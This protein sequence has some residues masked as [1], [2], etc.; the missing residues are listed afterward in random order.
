M[1]LGDMV[2]A[3]GHVGVAHEYVM[4]HGYVVSLGDVVIAHKYVMAHE[5]VMS[6][7][8]RWILEIW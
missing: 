8:M 4:Y 6:C 1:A 2:M 5:D 7:C 3:L